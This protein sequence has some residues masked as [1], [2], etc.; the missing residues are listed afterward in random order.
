MSPSFLL[1][2]DNK[3]GDTYAMRYNFVLAY[4]QVEHPTLKDF[5]LPDKTPKEPA[6]DDTIIVQRCG[7]GC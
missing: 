4:V 1:E 5:R 3:P 6:P 2:V 7:R